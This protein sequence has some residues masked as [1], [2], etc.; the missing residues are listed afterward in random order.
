MTRIG[1]TNVPD[2]IS[3]AFIETDLHE[4]LPFTMWEY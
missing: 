4:L 3:R 1:K 2:L